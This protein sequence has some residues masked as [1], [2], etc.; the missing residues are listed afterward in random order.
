MYTPRG[1]TP[2]NE[3][4]WPSSVLT[5]QSGACTPS[6]PLSSAGYVNVRQSATG[7]TAEA[8]VAMMPS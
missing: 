1:R 4:P 7:G 3:L 8:N 2:K 6:R 5:K